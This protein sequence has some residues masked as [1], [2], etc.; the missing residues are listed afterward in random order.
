M[1][2]AACHSETTGW[3]P[4]EDL[5]SLSDLRSEAGN[6][7]WA[8]IDATDLT[9]DAASLISDEF[10]LHPLAVEDAVNGRQRPKLEFYDSHLFAVVHQLDEFNG[11]LEASQIALFVGDRWV[12]TVSHGAERLVEEA[13]NRW[14]EAHSELA[15]GP[16][17]LVHKLLDVVVDDYQ[18]I[19]D[20]LEAEVEDLEDIVLDDPAAP[21]Q[22]RIYSMKQRVSRLRRY[23]L[24]AGRLL[25]DITRHGA[26]RFSAETS[27]YFRDVAD[28]VLRITDQIRTIDDLSS[29]VL[30]LHR[31][32]Q[33]TQLN[34]VTK[35]LTGWA[36][37]IA[38][39]TLI[40][41]TYGMNFELLPNEGELFGFIFAVM[42]M[43]GLG[44]GLYV[45]F[46]RK[47]WI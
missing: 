39:P 30:E 24:P 4:V 6:L 3:K 19:A 8:E 46:K 20:R 23:A 31:T 13:K 7:L 35:K 17:A 42:L 11:Q 14:E 45:F 37:I 22:R 34:D 38:V 43:F 33:T 25:D 36:A 15:R 41:S 40:A 18:V 2:K 5:A 9:R 12:L 27:A 21:V 16:S 47:G 29:A 26:P 44:I 32:E 10:G 1:L 28:H